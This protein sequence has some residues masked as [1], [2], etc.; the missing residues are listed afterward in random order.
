MD[1]QVLGMNATLLVVALLL[2]ILGVVTFHYHAYVNAGGRRAAFNAGMGG[3]VALF[4]R[5]Q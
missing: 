2:I 3:R 4:P 1:S 5:D